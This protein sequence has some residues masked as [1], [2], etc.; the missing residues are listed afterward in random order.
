MKIKTIALV[1]WMGVLTIISTTAFA[2]SVDSTETR[3]MER[4]TDKGEQDKNRLNNARE[5]KRSTKSDAKMAKANAKEANRIEDDASDAAKQARQ[6]ARS[7]MRAQ[8]SRDNADKQARKAAKASEKS[9][10][11]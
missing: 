7:E 10:N 5:L 8:K 11:N 6:A 9:N 1:V 4:Q 3:V 2:Q